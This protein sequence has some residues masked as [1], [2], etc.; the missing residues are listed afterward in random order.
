M[1]NLQLANKCNLFSYSFAGANQ[2]TLPKTQEIIPKTFQI[3]AKKPSR[4]WKK[5][6]KGMRPYWAYWA[7]KKCTKNKP[8]LEINCLLTMGD[9]STWNGIGAPQ[10]S[11]AN[12]AISI[13]CMK[14]TESLTPLIVTFSRTSSSKNASSLNSG[15]KAVTRNASSSGFLQAKKNGNSL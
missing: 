8:V 1:A 14:R 4:I 6:L 11:L 3:L 9:I 13:P 2:E 10:A 15:E 7:S 12:M 5:K